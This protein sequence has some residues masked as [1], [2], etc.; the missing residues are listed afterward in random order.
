MYN[1][2]SFIFFLTILF[3]KIIFYAVR[4]NIISHRVCAHVC[5]TVCVF[6]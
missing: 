5:V 6:K 3:T 2:N 4:E 1:D